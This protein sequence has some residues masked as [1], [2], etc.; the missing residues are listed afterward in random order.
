[1]HFSLENWQLVATILMILLRINWPNFV[2]FS[3]LAINRTTNC[4]VQHHIFNRTDRQKTGLSG[5]KPGT[6]GDPNQS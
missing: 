4:P 1:V 3:R 2:Q 5:Q 6:P